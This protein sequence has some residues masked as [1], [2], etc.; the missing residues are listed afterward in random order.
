MSDTFAFRGVPIPLRRRVSP[1]TVKV[2]AVVLAVSFAVGW[3][4]SWV[5]A[6]ERESFLAAP[7]PVAGNFVDTLHGAPP[8]VPVGNT[9]A[10]T[11][12][13]RLARSA[14]REALVAALQIAHGPAALVEAG[15][16]QL[17]KALPAVT[18]ADGPSGAPQVVSV[19]ATRGAWAAAVMSM[20]GRC[21]Y[22]RVES[23]GRIDY[24]SSITDCTGAAALDAADAA[25]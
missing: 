13:D 8:P 16:A 24:G 11:P 4:G 12:D 17:A 2:V 6:S 5:A 15:P 18:F 7:Q 23:R 9:V 10:V 21:F 3:F 22:V 1:R 14:A 20:S 19:A 25:W